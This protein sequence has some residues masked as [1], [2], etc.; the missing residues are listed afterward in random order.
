MKIV[1]RYFPKTWMDGRKEEFLPRILTFLPHLRH[2]HL[3]HYNTMTY[4]EWSSLTHPSPAVTSGRDI[5]HLKNYSKLTD[6][7][8]RV[9]DCSSFTAPPPEG[10]FPVPE[11]AATRGKRKNPD[12][13]PTFLQLP[14]RRKRRLRDSRPHDRRTG[15]RS[16]SNPYSCGRVRC[17]SGRTPPL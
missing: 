11:T 16:C 7:T 12:R 17:A 15:T 3:F 13:A 10:P 14:P 5:L 6:N 2:R 1:G 8:L 9:K 4:G